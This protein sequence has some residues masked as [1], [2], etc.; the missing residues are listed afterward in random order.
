MGKD[1]YGI[2]GV[3]RDADDAAMKKAY[4]KNAMKWHP[5]KNQGSP[6]AEAKFKEC[7]EAY[8]VLSYSSKRAI[9]DRYGEEGLKHGAGV[10]PGTP[11]G[12]GGRAPS[13][14]MPQGGFGQGFSA[15]AGGAP[16][17]AQYQ[18]SGDDAFNIFEQ[19]FGAGAGGMG[20]GFAPRAGGAQQ[21]NSAKRGPSHDVVKYPV[22]LE[23]LFTGGVKK[24]KVTRKVNFV[25]P[26]APGPN[27][28]TEVTEVI[29]IDIKPGWRSGTKLT[30]DKKGDELPGKPGHANDLVVVLSEKPHKDYT[31]EGDDLLAVVKS[32]PLQQALCGV[33]LSVPGIDG[34]GTALGVSQ[35]PILFAHARL[36]LSI[37][38][39]KSWSA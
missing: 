29:E 10:G 24:L 25:G 18:F 7:A 21:H 4:R 37:S 6:D 2:L 28:M 15:R 38:Y 31:R 34:E 22:A 13:S 36:T 27:A 17:G 16:G 12:R 39:R 33:R 8:D 11:E 1:Y 3:P 9:Y 35:I 20:G 14:E 19:L 23:D 5:D 26:H 32:I 30:Y